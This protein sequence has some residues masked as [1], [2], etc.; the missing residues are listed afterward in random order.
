MDRHRR[1]RIVANNRQ[2]LESKAPDGYKPVV[3][4][5]VA[6]RTAP[7]EIDFV[8]T[9]RAEDNPWI[10]FQCAPPASNEAADSLADGPSPD[11]YFVLIH[12]GLIERVE[13]HYET[14]ATRSEK[15]PFGFR[16]VDEDPA[17]EADEIE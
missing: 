7:L 4:V 13:I 2:T 16:V 14:T 11:D 10:W 9:S 8:E 15:Q 6:G 17:A 12:E 3:Q 5:F 1:W